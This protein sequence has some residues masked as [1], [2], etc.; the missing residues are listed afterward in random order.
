MSLLSM[1]L[2][3][4]FV[5]HQV[6]VVML[7]LSVGEFRDG[8]RGLTAVEMADWGG[9]ESTVSKYENVYKD[10]LLWGGGVTEK[11]SLK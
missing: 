2:M 1:L 9:R 8:T 4:L 7:F 10:W 3:L 5:V 11:P 6:F